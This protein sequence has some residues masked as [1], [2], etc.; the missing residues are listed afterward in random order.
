MAAVAG[1]VNV[2]GRLD[3]PEATGVADET[4]IIVDRNGDEIARL[5]GEQNRVPL[6]LVEVSPIL[7]N[8]VI[9]AE[10]RDFFTHPGVDPVAIARA[11]WADV[12][13]Q[14]ALQGGSTITQQYVKNAFLT[15]DRT[16]VRKLKEASLSIKLER[17]TEKTEILEGYLNTIYF[18]RGSYGIGA[19][20]RVWFGVSAAEL[21]IAQSAYLAGLIR[22]PETADISRDHQVEEAYRRRT[23]VL[24]AMLE[25]GYISQSEFEATERQPIEGY[26]LERIAN[27]SV[28]LSPKAQAAGAG[29]VVEM[30]RRQLSDAYGSRAVF[31]GGLRV[32][33]TIDLDLQLAAY[34]A[35]TDILNRDG[36]PTA[37]V[38]VLDQIGGIRAL[39]GGRDFAVSQVNLA[40]GTDG[41]GS[42][43]QPGSS[44]KPIVLAEALRQGISPLSQFEAP[45]TMEFLGLDDGAV[46]SV[47]NYNNADLG[48]VDLF[49]ATRW[50]SNTVYAQL[51]LETGPSPV[52]RLAGELGVAAELDPVH[53]L[54]LGTQEVS[55]LDMATAYATFAGRGER[56]SP[57]LLIDVLDR[58]GKVIDRFAS[59]SDRVLSSQQADIITAILGDV[60]ASGTGR[61]AAVD[62]VPTAGKTGTTQ[63]YRDAWFVGYT[64]KFTTAVWVG[65]PDS[66]RSMLNV[67]GLGQVTGGSLPAVIWRDVTAAAHRGVEPGSFSAPDA[68]PGEVL[69]TNLGVTTTTTPPPA[70]TTTASEPEATTEG[71]DGAEEPETGDETPTSSSTEVPPEPTPDD[72]TTTTGPPPVEVSTTT[73]DPPAADEG[74]E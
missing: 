57:Q 6:A 28:Q 10:D 36:E 55:V 64:P 14:G 74:D 32:Q 54:V 20:A 39:V 43:R 61:N 7:I 63:D 68:F 58:E 53:S 15:P 25:E 1:F 33:S 24:V 59:S 51:I 40:T 65:F 67:A 52:Q 70:T 22:A 34:E 4:T 44:F 31:Q 37:A 26:T 71:G 50:S 62:G 42:G 30:M 27:A 16:L 35:A 18:G 19:A 8:A 66:N 13:S 12:R 60:I 29:Y 49:G 11:L 21:N 17:E 5:H 73:A 2:L 45:P 56:H 69:G 38:V 23:S 48:I 46:W 9:A 47:S 41:G 72:T 3:L